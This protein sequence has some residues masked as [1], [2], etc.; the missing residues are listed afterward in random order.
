MPPIILAESEKARNRRSRAKREK[1]YQE[2]SD[3]CDAFENLEGVRK[4][5]EAAGISDRMDKVRVGPRLVRALDREISVVAATTREKQHRYGWEE[6][7]GG[8]SDAIAIQRDRIRQE[9]AA[10][11][12]AA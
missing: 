10:G 8:G 1:R 4:R 2:F 5:M 7:C 6:V 11:K 9:R 3:L 12:E